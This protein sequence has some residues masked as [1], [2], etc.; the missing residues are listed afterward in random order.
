ME[1]IMAE[2]STRGGLLAQF[3]DDLAQAVETAGQ[4]VVAVKARRRVPGS[5]V[6]WAPAGIVVTADHVLE[7]EDDIRVQLP[8]GTETPATL[9][10]RDPSTDLAVLRVK[11]EGLAP[12]EV[13][14]GDA[15]R[16]GHF[17]LALGR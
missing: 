15:V 4:A 13:G 6:L 16:V 2:Q 8:D 17:V 9:A 10:G 1:A 5:G 7:R 3:S 11:T 12:A 14:D